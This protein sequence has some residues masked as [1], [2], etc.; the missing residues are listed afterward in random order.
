MAVLLC[1]MIPGCNSRSTGH[2][3][4]PSSRPDLHSKNTHPAAKQPRRQARVDQAKHTPH[5]NKLLGETRTSV[6]LIIWPHRELLGSEARHVESWKT[7]CSEADR[8]VEQTR[9]DG[10]E[11]NFLKRSMRDQEAATST[12][13]KWQSFGTV[14]AAQLCPYLTSKSGK[15]VAQGLRDLRIFVPPAG[16]PLLSLT[17]HG[18]AEPTL[19]DPLHHEGCVDLADAA[20]LLETALDGATP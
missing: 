6:R 8:H 5:D 4:S 17:V 19:S 2:R 18:E 9:P 20:A 11:L 13:S 15:R 7:I 1:A 14:V 16:E 12:P 10:S 3:R